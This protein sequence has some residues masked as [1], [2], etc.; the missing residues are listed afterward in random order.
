MIKVTYHFSPIVNTSSLQMLFNLL[1]KIITSNSLSKQFQH[2][3]TLSAPQDE[4]GTPEHRLAILISGG[5][6][7][8]N[9]K[10]L[11]VPTIPDGTGLSQTLATMNALR[12]WSCVDSIIGLCYDTT[13]SNTGRH[14]GAVAILEDMLEK[15][16]LHLEC[17][18]HVLELVVGGVATALFGKT[19]GPCD[20][21]FE[22][23]KLR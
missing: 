18:H 10:L 1:F 5:P 19:T 3:S 9:G 8:V 20:T 2:T 16:V 14:R 21:R 7:H 4:L 15:K 13:S 12:E 11:S 6:D 23:L 22:Q 17:R